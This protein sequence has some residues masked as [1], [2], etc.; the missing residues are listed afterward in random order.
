MEVLLL[1][2]TIDEFAMANLMSYAGKELVSAEKAKLQV[3]PDAETPAISAE[4]AGALCTWLA[5]AP[6]GWCCARWGARAKGAHAS[7]PVG[8]APRL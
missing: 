7:P 4:D 5:E 6:P 8:G 1:T 3:E 2:S